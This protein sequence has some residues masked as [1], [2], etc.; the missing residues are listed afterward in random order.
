MFVEAAEEMLTKNLQADV[1]AGDMT[2]GE[3]TEAL[4]HLSADSIVKY[5]D[6]VKT[7]VSTAEAEADHHEWI[8]EAD[9]RTIWN[10]LIK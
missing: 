7:I 8:D 9:K 3:M 2:E 4:S 1:F 6:E 10:L 5:S